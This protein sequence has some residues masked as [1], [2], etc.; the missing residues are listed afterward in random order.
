MQKAG[1]EVDPKQIEQWTRLAKRAAEM[2]HKDIKVMDVFEFESRKRE[3]GTR[4]LRLNTDR[5]TDDPDPNP[6]IR[7]TF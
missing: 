2:R 6:R 3:C 5:S 1:E 7:S 4:S